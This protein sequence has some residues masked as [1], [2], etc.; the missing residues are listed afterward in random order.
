MPR[1][2][3]W[4]CP[5]CKMEA[6]ISGFDADHPKG[7]NRVIRSQIDPART[8]QGFPTHRDCQLVKAIHNI[9]FSRL[10]KVREE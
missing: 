7:R 4:K 9:D 6:E 5:K 10:E 3:I 2:Q 1:I 8:T